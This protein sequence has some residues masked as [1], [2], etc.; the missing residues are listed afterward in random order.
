[1]P[2]RLSPPG[3]DYRSAVREYAGLLDPVPSAQELAA[4][5][6]EPGSVQVSG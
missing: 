6:C 1:M 5:C 2:A 3:L 4:L